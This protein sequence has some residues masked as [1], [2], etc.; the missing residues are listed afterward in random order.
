VAKSALRL[1]ARNLRSI[2]GISIKSIATNLNVSSS[3]VSLWCRDIALSKEQIIKLEKQARDPN[4]GRRLEYSL[5]QQKERKKHTQELIEKSQKEIGIL[6]NREL[7]LVGIGLYWAEG[8]KKDNL[9]GFANSDIKMI[10]VFLLWVEK[11]LHIPISSLK[12]RLGINE[13]YTGDIDRIEQYWSKNL[14]LKVSQFQKPYIQKVLW[15]KQYDHPENYYG[16]LRIRIPKS[17]NLLRR[18]SGWI[19]G[20]GEIKLQGL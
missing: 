3:T 6:S 18:I 2:E 1:I 4:Y 11:C 15:K 8:F 13:Q 20:L 19:L 16:I 14:H 5:Q 12:F 10:K 17:T 7:F 9:A